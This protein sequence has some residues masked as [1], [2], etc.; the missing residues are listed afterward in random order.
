MTK[1]ERE[2]SITY[3]EGIKEGYVEVKG[4][5]KGEGYE[6]YPLPEYFAIEMAI[7]ALKQEPVLD[8]IRD[9]IID[10]RSKQNVGVMECLDIIDKYRKE[11]TDA[12]SN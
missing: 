10:L 7:D 5:D 8:K 11:Q 4:Y 1:E 9:E 2:L 12:D 3:L 6:I